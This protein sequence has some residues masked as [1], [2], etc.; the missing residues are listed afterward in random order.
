M[1]DSSPLLGRTVSHYRI[2]E[3]LGGGGMGVV[4]KAEDLELGRFVALKFLPENVVN[5]PQTLERF[6]REARAASAL[7]HP[8]IGTIHEIGQDGGKPFIVMEF[9][10]G[11]TL[12]HRIGGRPLELELL[13]DLAIEITDAL[14]TAHAKGIIHRDIKPANIF[15]TSRDHAKILDFG[16]A[17]I[18]SADPIGSRVERTATLDH[19]P[20]HPEPNQLTS[21]GTALGTVLYMSPEQVLGKALDARTDLFSFAVVIYEMASGAIPFKGDSTG[22]IFD[23]IVHKEPDDPLRLNPALPAELAQVIH[24]GMEKDRELRYQSA[25]E[26]RADLKRLKR[27]VSS[28]RVGSARMGSSSGA[29]RI[30]A[31]SASGAALP[32]SSNPNLVPSP[33]AGPSRWKLISIIVAAALIVSVFAAYKFLRRPTEFK[34]QDMHITRLT[35]SGKAEHVAISPDG[36]YVVYALVDGE[37]Q[38]LWVRNVATKSDVQVLAPA[39]V[40]FNGLSFSPDGNRIYFVRADNAAD[41]SDLYVMPVLGGTPIQLTRSVNTAVSFSP[42]AKHFVF[43][44]GS[45][46]G[47]AVEVRIGDVDGGAD[48]PLVTLPPGPFYYGGSWSPD[49]E[50]IAV[51]A[52]EFVPQIRWVLKV[53]RVKDAQVSELYSSSDEIG[54]PSWMPDGRSLL[55][56]M[57]LF[58]E[59]GVQIWI[60]SYPDGHRK[61][62]TNDL[63]DYGLSIDL[64]RDGRTFAGIQRTQVSHIWVAP[65][66]QPSQAK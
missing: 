65:T 66:A 8:N 35:D 54:R 62:F 51:S 39:A 32:S 26:L 13:L 3:K 6:R 28:G 24:K 50:T 20:R 45:A 47:G 5:D 36:S 38:S 14:D 22:A 37:R 10:E 16:L 59:T 11:A 29:Q 7:N 58:N 41:V 33:A 61:R 49:G 63:A 1:N 19:E 2:L 12:K 27:D 44:R 15:V 64:T 60:V 17:K 53:I 42:D 56:P 18:A 30:I 21:P 52:V 55:V 40:V 9:L 57:G 25:A 23:E 34:L 4:Y 31:D 48:K 46:S 43:M